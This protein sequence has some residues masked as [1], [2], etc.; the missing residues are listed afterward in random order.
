VFKSG[1]IVA[2]L[3]SFLDGYLMAEKES[4]AFYDDA[5]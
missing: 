5:P 4:K 3:L 2:E 1:E